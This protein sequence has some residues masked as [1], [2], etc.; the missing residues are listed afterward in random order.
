MLLFKYHLDP[1][2]EFI[3]FIPQKIRGTSNCGCSCRRFDQIFISWKNNH[4][5]FPSLW[6]EG[7]CAAIL[8]WALLVSIPM[9][10]WGILML[11]INLFW[12]SP[13][14][15]WLECFFPDSDV[16]ESAMPSLGAFWQ[17]SYCVKLLQSGP[18]LIYM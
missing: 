2:R 12:C 10:R 9:S 7:V 8:L 4:L 3:F 18:I 6:S 1:D 16:G 5:C 14:K 11:V 17:P 13:R 15:K